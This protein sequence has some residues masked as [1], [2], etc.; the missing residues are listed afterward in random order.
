MVTPSMI[1]NAT[2][3]RSALAGCE[4]NIKY[5]CFPSV[6]FFCPLSDAVALNFGTDSWQNGQLQN[7]Y[8]AASGTQAKL[9][10][11]FD[12][13]VFP[14]DVNSV[15]NVANQFANDGGQFKINGRPVISSYLGKCLGNA[16]WQQVKDRTGG[17]LMPFIAEIEGQF[18]DWK[19]LDSWF[20]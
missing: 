11:S 15:V 16:G 19:S 1:G 9:F 5:L 10:L 13:S 8:N 3:N 12:F 6:Q 17:Y 18:G 14:C 20:W 7:A 2:F 4:Y